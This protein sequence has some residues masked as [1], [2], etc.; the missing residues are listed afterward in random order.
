M[1]EIFQ[2][3]KQSAPVVVVFASTGVFC[4]LLLE[5]AAK[6]LAAYTGRRP[7]ETGV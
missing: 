2:L 4:A 7:D 5:Q 1:N 3:A 6:S